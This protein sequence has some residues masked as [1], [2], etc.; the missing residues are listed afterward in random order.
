MR[1]KA[2]IKQKIKEVLNELPDDPHATETMYCLGFWD[3]LNYALDNDD[4]K[5]LENMKSFKRAC[6]R[7]NE[8]ALLKEIDNG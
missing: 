6:A 5:Q 1:T 7:A 2:E 3:A 4:W 8:E